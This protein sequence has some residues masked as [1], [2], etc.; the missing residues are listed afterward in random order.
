[1]V[2]VM[3]AEVLIFVPSVGRERLNV[4]EATIADA[5]LATLSLEETPNNMVSPELARRLLDTVGVRAIVLRGAVSRLVLADDM[6]PALDVT[7]DLRT[8]TLAN[9]LGDALAALWRGDNRVVRLIGASQQM[10]G[11]MVEVLMDERPLVA[12]L[13]AYAGEILRVS[14]LISLVTAL[15]IYLV[16]H[17]RL[18]RP[19][20]LITQSMVEFRHDPSN[21]WS[22]IR[23]TARDDEIGIAERE[24]STMQT[25]LRSALRQNRRLAELGHAVS[26]ISHDLRNILATATLVS[27]RIASLSDP[28]VQRLAPTL[29][30]AVDRAATLASE[31]LRY[32]R[33]EEPVPHRTWFD[34]H[35]LMED[36]GTSAGVGQVA[37]VAWK[38][39]VPERF[40]VNADRDQ[41]FRALLNLARNAVQAMD[42][43]ANAARGPGGQVV[44]RAQRINGHVA[45]DIIDTGPG[46]PP[47][48]RE[49]L[50]RPFSGSAR[51]G[52]TGLGLAIAR[53]IARAHRGDI[54]LVRSDERGT[55]FR[56]EIPDV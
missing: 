55:Q 34:L 36:V 37:R 12:H 19:M 52:G 4:L 21:P 50:F 35:D 38:N 43:E 8:A 31:T 53:D 11:A 41:V 2:F 7:V 25:D 5:D 20:A 1:M 28:E 17:W 29:V 39:E 9:T 42:G 18:V 40:S 45:I 6:P 13:S 33:A 30:R 26:K 54:H 51:A 16:L 27:D 44:A 24:L 3:V 48:A 56:L 32:G 49:A 10:P 47:K 14:I 23:P 22:V 15:L 46:L